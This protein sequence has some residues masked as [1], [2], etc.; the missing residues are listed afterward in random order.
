MSNFFNVHRR[1]IQRPLSIRKSW[2]DGK[3]Y[4]TGKTNIISCFC[5]CWGRPTA[6]RTTTTNFWIV[7][8]GFCD[9]LFSSD[10]LLRAILL[11]DENR[12][13]FL[14]PNIFCFP[15]FNF[16]SHK[17]F[18]VLKKS[19]SGFLAKFLLPTIVSIFFTQRG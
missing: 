6:T 10:V 2:I 14:M 13:V 17:S 11:S 16:F 12:G 18:W 7:Y 3:Q 9:P 1:T 15:P 4:W 5:C 19:L 8:E